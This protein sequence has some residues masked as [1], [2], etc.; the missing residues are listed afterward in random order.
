MK[1]IIIATAFF[2]AAF[3]SVSSAQGHS[4]GHGGGHSGGGHSGGGHS[5]GAHSGGGGHT[6]GGHASGG[7]SHAGGSVGSHGR[8]TGSTGKSGRSTAGAVGSARARTGTNAIGRSKSD[9]IAQTAEGVPPYSRPRDPSEPVVGIAVPRTTVPPSS[10]LGTTV[11]FPTGRSY[12]F[13][14]YPFSAGPGAYSVGYYDPLYGG[15]PTFTQTAVAYDEGSL[16][17]KITPRSAEVYVDGNYVGMVDD[18]DGIF[19][20]LHI[21]GGIHRIE[22]RAAGY[23]TLAFDARISPDHKTTYE[24]ELRRIQ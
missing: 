16:R 9:A 8:T 23:E 6:S 3:A 15:T 1:I 2:L 11:V 7:G 21:S 10:T 12:G 24:G 20:K 18:F 13:G 19:Q 17:L 5:G 14:F 4:G 22:V